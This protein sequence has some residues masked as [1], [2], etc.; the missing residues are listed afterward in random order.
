MRASSAP[1]FRSSSRRSAA[2]RSPILDSAVSSH[3]PRQVLDKLRDF[4]ETSYANVHRGVYTLSEVA[5]AEYE[6]ARE[7]V[8]AIRQ[9]A[10]EAREIDL[11][12]RRNG[13]HQSRRVRLGPRQPRP[14]RRRRRHRAR[15]PLELRPVA[16]HRQADGRGLPDDPDRRARRAP[17]RRARRRSHE[18]GTSRSSPTTSSRTRSAR[19]TRSSGSQRGPTSRAQSWSWTRRRQRRTMQSTCRR[20]DCDFLA[21]SPTRCAARRASV[22]SGAERSCSTRW[23]RSTS[24]AT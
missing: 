5:T 10:V 23:R 17:A 1:T 3:K 15:A 19:S 11:H 4:Y 14:G 16:V 12:A 9:R 6:G 13:E 18:R 21:F 7:K 8:R 20:S 24:A 2:S 22:R